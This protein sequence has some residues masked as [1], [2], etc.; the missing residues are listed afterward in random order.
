MNSTQNILLSI[1]SEAQSKNL[2]V[3]KTQLVKYLYLTEVEYYREAGS[4]LTDLDW[5]FYHYGPYAFELETIL[6]EKIF[7][8]EEIKIS[9]EK[10]FNKFTVAEPTKH[11]NDLVDVKTSLIIKRII[12]M[13]GDKP[14]QDLLDYVYF[15]TEPMQ[16]VDRRGQRLNFS[17]IKKDESSAIIPLKASKDA[18]K[19]I[20]VLRGRFSKRL[21]ELSEIQ[22]VGEPY[23]EEYKQALEAWEE[24][25]K[26]E[27]RDISK[28][29]V[30]ITKQK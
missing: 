8:H 16:V 4:R 23:T 20:A 2:H 25:E 24:E 29:Q 26:V 17:T 9:T 18:E 22:P 21:S 11:Y 1:L 19:R 27:P 5:K 6:E 15:E 10:S 3:G 30:T 13:W 28:I 14:L 7:K 12:G